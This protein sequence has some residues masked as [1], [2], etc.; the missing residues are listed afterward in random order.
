MMPAVV[1]PGHAQVLALEPE[2]MVPQDGN[3][4]QD[5]EKKAAKLLIRE[6]GSRYSNSATL[7]N[8]EN[9]PEVNRVEL[10]MKD[11]GGKTTF[12]NATVTGHSSILF[13]Q[14]YGVSVVSKKNIHI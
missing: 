1:K 2:F 8:E 6:A 10:A 5:C 3:E 7:N 4:T 12:H 14:T 11:D 13:R 9:A